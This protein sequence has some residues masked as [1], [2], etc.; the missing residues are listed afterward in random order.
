[1][2]TNGTLP[3]GSFLIFRGKDPKGRMVILHYSDPGKVK[4]T[5][6][7]IE[8]VLRLAY[9]EKPDSPDIF[10]LKEGNF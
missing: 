6:N 4:P 8:P 3:D 10:K 9:I 2:V 7:K 1:M 5:S